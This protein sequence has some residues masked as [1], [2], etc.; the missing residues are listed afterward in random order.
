LWNRSTTCRARTSSSSRSPSSGTWCSTPALV[1]LPI[2]PTLPPLGDPVGD[3]RAHGDAPSRRMLHRPFGRGD[4]R[5]DFILR[6]LGQ[7]F[8]A[9][10]VAGGRIPPLAAD[11]TEPDPELLTARVDSHLRALRLGRD[12]HT[13]SGA[14]NTGAIVGSPPHRRSIPYGLGCRALPGEGATQ[15]RDDHRSGRAGNASMQFMNVAPRMHAHVMVI[16]A[17]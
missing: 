15:A 14:N 1:V 5:H 8:L 13:S 12:L 4:A 7:R 16:E 6:G 17:R 9:Y 3:E 2:E 11:V 10:L